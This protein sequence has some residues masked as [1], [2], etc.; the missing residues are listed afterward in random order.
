MK[1]LFFSLIF[2]LFSN[3][4][5]WLNFFFSIIKVSSKN[6]KKKKT[7][8]LTFAE[9]IDSGKS[10]I[11]SYVTA[12]LFV[13]S[14]ESDNIARFSQARWTEYD[15]KKFPKEKIERKKI[16]HYKEE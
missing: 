15:E 4:K 13:P 14:V 5:S 11:S 9:V 7:T 3:F 2:T 10:L 8:Y 16:G 12:Q 6:Y 1:C